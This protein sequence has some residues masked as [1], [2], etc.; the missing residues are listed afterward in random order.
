M[1]CQV[2]DQ[3]LSA[4]KNV[5][6]SQTGLIQLALM[7]KKVGFEKIIKMIDEMVVPDCVS[8]SEETV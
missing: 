5:K 2:R 8:G 3:A 4:L 7:G 1:R 6:D